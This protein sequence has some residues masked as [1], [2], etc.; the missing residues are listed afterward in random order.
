MKAVIPKGVGY[1]F[2][3][4]FS[5]HRAE[6]DLVVEVEKIKYEIAY[7]KMNGKPL[8]MDSRLLKFVGI[9]VK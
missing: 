1:T 5:F 4:P 9:D 6:K 8:F 3:N 2:T 7:C